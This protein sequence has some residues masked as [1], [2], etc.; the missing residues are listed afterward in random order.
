VKPGPAW[1]EDW[2]CGVDPRREDAIGQRLLEIFG[3]FW[4]D[5]GIDRMSATSRRRH[6]NALHAVGGHLLARALAE[7]GLGLTAE[8]LLAEHVTADDGPL[9]TCDDEAWQNEVDSVCRKLHRH[10][11]SATPKAQRSRPNAQG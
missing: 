1:L 9:V 11:A 3:Q 10:L 2:R 8:E 5:S 4:D 6:A 7:D